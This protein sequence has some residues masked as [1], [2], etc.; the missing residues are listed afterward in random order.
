M[1]GVE[2]QLQILPSLLHCIVRLLQLQPAA[3]A[4]VS[5]QKRRESS[6]ASSEAHDAVSRSVAA[7]ELRADVLLE[8]MLGFLHS[9]SLE[10]QHRY[11]C[12]LHTQHRSCFNG[13]SHIHQVLVGPAKKWAGHY[14]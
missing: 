7:Q 8:K 3:Y 6:P 12:N 2:E 11:T 9:S 14:Q 4:T 13:I 5:L 10:L 1:R